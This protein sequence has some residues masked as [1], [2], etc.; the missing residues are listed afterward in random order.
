MQSAKMR[1]RNTPIKKTASDHVKRRSM[2]SMNHGGKKGTKGK[3]DHPETNKG[4]LQ[5]T[6]RPYILKRVGHWGAEKALKTSPEF[7]ENQSVGYK[8]ELYL[9]KLSLSFE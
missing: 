4:R 3:D 9:I 8:N 1:T 6:R 7:Q 2:R 5:R